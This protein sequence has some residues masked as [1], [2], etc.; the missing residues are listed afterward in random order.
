MNQAKPKVL[1]VEDEYIVSL[2]IQTR[3]IRMGYDVAGSCNS[4]EEAINR[5]AQ[6]KPDLVLMD[7]ML[8]GKMNGIA[9]AKKIRSQMDVAVI[10]LTGYSDDATL[11][12]AT[13]AEPFG[14]IVKPFDE[15]TLKTTIEV[16]LARRRN[17]A[18]RAAARRSDSRSSDEAPPLPR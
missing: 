12:E 2:D 14:Y 1:V 18:Q 11:R 3:L 15:R 5:A 7:I 16:S 9:A 10:F 13:T 6:I 8:A 4:G 17:E